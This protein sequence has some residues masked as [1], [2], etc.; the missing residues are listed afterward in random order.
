M[1]LAL[2]LVAIPV[3]VMPRFGAPPIWGERWLR[4]GAVVG[5][6]VLTMAPWT[7]Y[8]ATRFDRPVLISTNDGLALLGANCPN[9]YYGPGLGFWSLQCGEAFPVPATEDQSQHSARYR[10][11]GLHYART[12]VSRL[13]I[14]ALAREARVW[15]AWRV[16]Q[17]VWLNV[18]E[19]REQWASRIGVVQ[20]WLLAPLAVVGAIVLGR[21]RVPL[22]PLLA[23]FALVTIVALAFYGIPRFRLPADVAAVVLA[24]AAIDQGF[25][26]LSRPAAP[27]RSG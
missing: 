14:V 25:S 9:T 4:V 21:R 8:N 22:L 10:A 19:G 18:G 20:W 3:I 13:P 7:I 5:V 11:E 23:M 1:L 15:S 27:G 26:G 12:H 24:A 2:P 6:L 16:D 17:M